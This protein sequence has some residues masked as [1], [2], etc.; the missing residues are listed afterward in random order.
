MLS[1]V[2]PPLAQL[3]QEKGNEANDRRTRFQGS[4][5]FLEGMP[6]SLCNVQ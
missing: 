4:T 5:I 2:C 6:A 3:R 1:P